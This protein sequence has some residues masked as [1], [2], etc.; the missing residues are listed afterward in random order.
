MSGA[1]ELFGT[2]DGV[3]NIRVTEYG[4][5]VAYQ[6][7]F[8]PS[9][10]IFVPW[11]EIGLP[12]F[13]ESGLRENYPAL[14]RHQADAI[15]AVR[16]GKN[17]IVT[18]RTSSGKSLIYTV[19]IAL[20]LGESG[21]ST[22]LL[23]Y[24]QKAL[25]N[26]QL[27]S[28]QR[29]LPKTLEHAGK[30]LTPS[31]VARYDAQTPEDQRPAIRQLSRVV[32]TNPEMMHL[33]MLGW[34]ERHW[35]RFL[36]NLRYVI[37][38]EAH[39]YRGTFGSNVAM[40]MRRLRVVADRYGAQP[41]FIATSATIAGPDEHLEKLTGCKFET[42]PP[43]A[44][45]SKQGQKRLWIVRPKGHPFELAR[46]LMK[47]LVAKGL[48][49][50]TFC[51]SR[52]SA[53]RLAHDVGRVDDATRPIVVYRAGLATEERLRIEDGLKNGRIGGVFATSALELG[54]D[55][56]ALDV[57]ICVGFPNTMMS[58]WQR[59]GRVGRGGKTGAVI[60]IPDERPI[61]AYYTQHPEKLFRR[62]LEPLAINLKSRP[63]ATWHYACA[64]SEASRNIESVNPDS[65]GE[66][67]ATIAREHRAGQDH[68]SY[69]S[70]SV[71]RE[72]NLRAGGDASY[73]LQ[74][75]DVHLGEISRS[76]IL[77]ETPPNA[78]YFHGG[79][80]Y[81]VMSVDESRKIVRVRP[82]H[83]ANR[84]Q[85]L[86][87]TNVRLQQCWRAGTNG[88]I[89]VEEG[90]LLVT[91][92]LLSLTEKR[93]DGTVVAS[94]QGNQG[95]RSNILPTTG[96]VITLVNAARLSDRPGEARVA[97]NGLGPLLTGLLPTVLGPCDLGDFAIHP[98]WGEEEAKLYLY[99]VAYDGIDLTV[100][101]FTALPELLG[102]ALTRIDE[103]DCTDSAGCFRCV[104][105]PYEDVPTSRDAT[106]SLLRRLSESLLR[107]PIV[108]TVEVDSPDR[109]APPPTQ[110]EC[111][112]CKHKN[113]IGQKFCG[114]CGQ[115]L[116]M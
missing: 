24:P 32:L 94:R 113:P 96:V 91:Q 41:Q 34:H 86:V 62:E 5:E 55:I 90:K 3:V 101:A 7:E 100:H 105:N 88:K 17:V 87:M 36:T 75:D 15:R 38:D 20:M 22:A 57:C 27:A 74:L 52:Q 4:D 115:K 47:E 64:L 68:S 61:D 19:P 82:E 13:I 89:K 99:D 108:V 97:F 33:A 29:L 6:K 114:D 11:S 40:L 63:L 10:G 56:G 67:M 21:A 107:A 53:E 23:C 92:S 78:I 42:V 12:A 76:Q 25:A 49:V 43:E 77:R 45:G 37:L 112:V 18:T 73:E 9:D 8:R 84:T 39:D 59:A 69:H 106:R 98:A 85:S 109:L 1:V 104:R 30:R 83:T 48:T 102:A 58:L 60:L 35:Q 2:V 72:Y 95:L 71:H 50:L 16:S 54:I 65:L 51:Q 14:Y 80:K 79:R 44:D 46:A 70:E 93:P 26:D 110:V 103:C 31:I 116:E 81:R 28:F 66:P 111:P